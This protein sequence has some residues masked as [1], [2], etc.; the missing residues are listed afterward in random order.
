MH[1]WPDNIDHPVQIEFLRKILASFP[2]DQL[3]FAIHEEFDARLIDILDVPRNMI[4]QSER[5]EDYVNLY[6]EQD[7]VIL[8]MRLHAGMLGLANGVPVAFIGHDT[9]TYSF[10]QMMGIDYLELFTGDVAEKTVAVL[11]RL[12]EGDVNL[13]CKTQDNYRQLHRAMLR[14]LRLNGLP[15]R[16]QEAMISR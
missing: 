2:A 8:A 15:E 14:F 12:A 4:F 13:F 16:R 1:R 3:V 9:R 11:R 6:T 5:P 10:C 7:Q